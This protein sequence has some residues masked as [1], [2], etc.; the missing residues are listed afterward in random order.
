VTRPAYGMGQVRPSASTSAGCR[1]AKLDR[2][3][4]RVASDS[5][6]PS[7]VGTRFFGGS[8]TGKPPHKASIQVNRTLAPAEEP[9]TVQITA[10]AIPGCTAMAYGFGDHEFF[11]LKIMSNRSPGRRLS[12]LAR[13]GVR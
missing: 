11:K 9:T 5:W 1:Y 6:P 10:L 13:D 12:Q 3:E 8:R 7:E 2:G 4:L